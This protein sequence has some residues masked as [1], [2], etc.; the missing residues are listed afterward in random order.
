M[1]LDNVRSQIA[2][3]IRRAGFGTTQAELDQY[4]ALGYAGPPGGNGQR[5]HHG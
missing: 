4:A 3:L 2:H 1:A 5:D